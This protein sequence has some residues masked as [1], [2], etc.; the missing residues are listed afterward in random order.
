MQQRERKGRR[1]VRLRH[2]LILVVC[3]TVILPARAPAVEI[4]PFQLRNQDPLHRI[5][6]LPSPGDGRVLAPGS[7]DAGLTFDLANSY[8]AATGPGEALLL[9]GESYRFNLILR[10][11]LPNGFEVGLE[12]PWLAYGGGTI[13]G[14][15]QDWHRFFGLPE[16]GRDQ[17]PNNRLRYL[18]TRT[19]MRRLAVTDHQAGIG[20]LMLTGGWQCAGD[21]TTPQALSLRGAI[22]IPTGD[23]SI[24]AGSG[25]TDLSLWLIGRSDHSFSWGK[26]SV[27]ASL[28]G[29]YL[30]PGDVLPDLQSHWVAFGT[31]G[32]GWSPLEILSFSIQLDASTPLYRGSSLST[33]SGNSLG[34][35]IGG[36]VLLG[37][38]TTLQLGVAEDLAVATWPD[39]TFHLGLFRRF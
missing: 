33:L 31:L 23:S 36:S 14:F 29:S 6:G 17:A 24:L 2:L 12:L 10:G 39:V 26:T 4:L 19:G 37:E 32:A 25:S 15:I 11:G 20:D 34:L 8:V 7:Y 35:L 18:Y 16:G 30:S 3:L 1:P 38:R 5:F 9:D 13:D 21:A 22:K 28:G 27:Y